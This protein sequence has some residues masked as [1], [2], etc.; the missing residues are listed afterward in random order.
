[1]RVAIVHG[2][3]LDRHAAWLGATLRE[4]GVA[5]RSYRPDQVVAAAAWLSA[6]AAERS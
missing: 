5:V 2:R 6:T 3:R 4:E 1:M